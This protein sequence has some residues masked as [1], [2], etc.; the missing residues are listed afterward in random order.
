M[1]L[2]L[3]GGASEYQTGRAAV[4]S[5]L[6]TL[7]PSAKITLFEIDATTV[8]DTIYRFHPG[9]NGLTSNIVWQGNTYSAFP[10][11]A[12][13]FEMSGKGT[14]PRPR[15]R[16]SNV[17][18]TISSL[19][20]AFQDLAGCKVTRIRTLA[21][22]LDEV[23]FAPPKNRLPS[24][25]S[26]NGVWVRG[27]GLTGVTS[28]RVDPFGGFTATQFNGMTGQ[29]AIPTGGVV[30]SSVAPIVVGKKY[31]ISVWINPLTTGTFRIRY[32]ATADTQVASIPVT[33]GSG[34]QRVS[35][36]FTANPAGGTN[37]VVLFGAASAMNAQLYGV[38]FEEGSEMTDYMS[39]GS[40]LKRNPTADPTAEYPRDIYYIDR[41]SAET[42]DYVE[43][44]LASATD[45]AGVRL[46]RRQIVQNC[47]SWRYR[48]A[49]CGYTGT[50]YF[51]INDV[52]VGSL[53]LDVCGKRLSSCRARFGSNA[54]LPY[55]GFPA[56]GL[57]K[58]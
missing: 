34:W 47:C 38:Q 33:A 28:G 55:G 45:L 54:E 31:T 8:G 7:S 46:P 18:G 43:F 32:G 35:A 1:S 44:E 40:V 16:V 57:V 6:Q 17:L 11:E 26:L 52:A 56:A 36:T 25:D 48:G 27:S 53:S 42:R 19:V 50:S 22:F 29:S 51:N 30:F 3:L 20:L 9:V 49:E 39:N 58:Q 5:E 4:A 37:A 41:R 13:G 23:N 21:K 15:L 24:T 12:S 2:L 10:I 14:L